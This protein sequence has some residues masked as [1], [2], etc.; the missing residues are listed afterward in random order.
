MFDLSKFKLRASASRAMQDYLKHKDK[1]ALI[2]VIRTEP[3]TLAE[4]Q[5]FRDFIADLI[6]GKV[7]RAGREFVRKADYL[8]NR[9]II[10]DI[11]FYNAIGYPI[12][13][14]YEV[15]TCCYLA[16]EKRGG[17]PKPDTIR[18][19]YLAREKYTAAIDEFVVL[20]KQKRDGKAFLN[21][22]N[23]KKPE[24]LEALKAT[25]AR[26]DALSGEERGMF[27]TEADFE[28]IN[29]ADDLKSWKET[30]DRLGIPCTKAEVKEWIA[31][32]F[33]G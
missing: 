7:K 2:K 8:R 24:T 26:F 17:K 19:Y 1:S 27:Y 5:I 28:A 23:G 21:F 3:E 15:L 18:K 12:I 31:V 4:S 16:S 33:K 20:F 13:N 30:F 25:L 11:A 29:D 32:H 14:E 9:E 22:C 6:E 10:I